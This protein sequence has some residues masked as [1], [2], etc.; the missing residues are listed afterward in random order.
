[1]NKDTNTFIHPCCNLIIWDVFISFT[2]II[3]FGGQIFPDP[4]NF[5]ESIFTFILSVI[6]A[7][8]PIAL[9]A[10]PYLGKIVQ[11]LFSI[12]W[13]IAG[14][15]LLDMI[16]NIS[17]APLWERVVFGLIIFLLTLS[18]HLACAGEMNLIPPLP[19]SSKLR[20]KPPMNPAVEARLQQYFDI[21]D[22]AMDMIKTVDALPANE[23]SLPLKNYIKQ[24][25]SDMIKQ[26]NHLS[27][28][29]AS[30]SRNPDP[31]TLAN[32]NSN[33]DEILPILVKYNTTFQDLFDAYNQSLND[34]S[35]GD[36]GPQENTHI[37]FFQ[38]C[39]SLESLNKR[40]KDLV[41]V[42]HPDSG[43]GNDKVFIEITEEYEKLKPSFQN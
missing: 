22:K 37:S 18:L 36:E 26:M 32:L 41:K 7:L 24:N 2:T 20:D 17:E 6:I 9:M 31:L 27:N 15:E 34:A 42:Y 11:I 40:Y 30:Y 25:F 33:L 4:S 8:I 29:I 1:M 12:F 39:D 43:N 5:I 10:I 3:R 28:S 13:T 16:F 35:A 38:G 14:Y 23:H 19:L 21:H